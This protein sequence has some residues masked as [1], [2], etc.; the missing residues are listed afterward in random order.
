MPPRLVIISESLLIA[1]GAIES[2]ANEEEILLV[3]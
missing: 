2:K 3:L 1:C